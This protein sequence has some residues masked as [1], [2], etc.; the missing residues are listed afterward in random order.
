M[1]LYS[2]ENWKNKLYWNNLIDYSRLEIHFYR[3]QMALNEREEESDLLLT[4]VDDALVSFLSCFGCSNYVRTM[5]TAV[6]AQA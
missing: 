3:K 2:Q 4:E 5:H 1:I 6:L